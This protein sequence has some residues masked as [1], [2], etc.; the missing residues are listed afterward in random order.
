MREGHGL[1][2]GKPIAEIHLRIIP[3]QWGKMVAD[4]ESLAPMKPG[5][6]VVSGGHVLKG[7]L[8][9]EG[10]SETKFPIDGEIWHRTGDAGYLD[11]EGRLWLLGRC[12]AKV[13]DAYGELYPFTA[14]CV[15]MSFP[16]VRRCAFVLH[17]GKR[18]LAVEGDLSG[19]NADSLRQSLLWAKLD[20]LQK[21]KTIPVDSRHNAKV[22]Y[23]KLRKLLAK[24]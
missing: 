19:S 18:L 11:H 10:D 4:A 7:Y 21:V 20:E 17:E 9:G 12:S 16:F 5:E 23:P 22:N 2:T 24:H 1:L 6:I 15:A 8:D 3:D 13:S 14:E